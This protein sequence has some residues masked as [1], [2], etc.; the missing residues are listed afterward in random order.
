MYETIQFYRQIETPS[1]VATPPA[2]G[3]YAG[4]GDVVSS[5]VAWWGLRAYSLATVGT[6]AIRLRRDS[7]NTESDFNT[8]TNGTLDVA[9]VTTFKG[10]ANLFVTKLYDQS[11]GTTNLVQATAA[12]QPKLILS[13]I[14]SRPAMQDNGS[15]TTLL[16]SSVAMAAQI[17]P[18]TFST[19][20]KVLSVSD[21][22]IHISSSTLLQ[23]RA[24]LGAAN[25]ITIAADGGTFLTATAADNTWH[26]V[27]AVF[28]GA[29]SDNNLDGTSNVGNAGT[30]TFTG[31]ENAQMFSFNAGSNFFLGHITELGLWGS[32][33]SGANSTA[34]SANQHSYWGF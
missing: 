34:M 25:K 21:G 12:N 28:N 23:V 1:F 7:D 19:A 5:A 14:G 3:P 22:M 6:A 4:P 10:A 17:E 9:S 11:G 15:A 26:A 27:Q 20:Y 2:S 32:A 31:A 8:L 13:A 24:D 18:M 30:G 29:S 16:Q 33:F